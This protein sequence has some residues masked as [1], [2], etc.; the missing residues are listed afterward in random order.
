[1]I[2]FYY[3]PSVVV[4]PIY[5]TKEGAPSLDKLPEDI[6]ANIITSTELMKEKVIQ[7]LLKSSPAD[8]EIR[9][10][11]AGKHFLN[12]MY[13]IVSLITSSHKNEPNLSNNL[14]DTYFSGLDFLEN[15][16]SQSKDSWIA[17]S[18]LD[19]IKSIRNY[20]IFTNDP[21]TNTN[22]PEYYPAFE[23][24]INILV[25]LFALT[26]ILSSTEVSQANKERIELLIQKCKQS[27]KELNYYVQ[28]IERNEDTEAVV[29]GRREYTEG[30]TESFNNVEDLLKAL[31][32]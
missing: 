8:F 22:K 18:M 6:R 3:M 26:A 7:P 25:C 17:S 2:L 21:N 14:A 5:P 31:K 15:E 23:T 1:M 30:K 10:E 24:Y 19:A 27:S 11:E 29:E 4:I 16:L 9:F 32:S 28:I 13:H 20:A 12:Y